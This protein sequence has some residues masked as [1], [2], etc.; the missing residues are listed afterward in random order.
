MMKS[1][2][3]LTNLL[4]SVVL[5]SAITIVG[6]LVISWFFH[7]PILLFPSADRIGRDYLDRIIDMDLDGIAAMAK[8]DENREC[9]RAEGEDGIVAYG[10]VKVRNVS[11][12]TRSGEGSDDRIEWTIVNFEYRQSHGDSWRSGEIT[13]MTNN[14]YNSLLWRSLNCIGG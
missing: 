12:S 3:V 14:R 7:A 6:L 11:V 13:I 5:V 10:G 9:V 4:G 2:S 1:K 8:D